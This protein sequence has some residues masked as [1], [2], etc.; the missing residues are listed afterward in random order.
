MDDLKSYRVRV[1]DAWTISLGNTRVHI[2][3]PPAGGA[4]LAFVLKLIEGFI[5][6][7]SCDTLIHPVAPVKLSSALSV[8]SSELR[9][10]E[11]KKLQR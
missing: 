10:S 4:L 3:P 11:K 1:E 2:P 6:R 8:A 5:P 7:L 9:G